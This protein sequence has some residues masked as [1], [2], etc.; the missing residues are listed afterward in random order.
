MNTDSKKAEQTCTIADVTHRFFT[1]S[2][3]KETAD[4]AQKEFAAKEYETKQVLDKIK[5]AAELGEYSLETYH[6]ENIAKNL[7]LIGYNVS[8]GFEGRFHQHYM[9]V[10]WSNGG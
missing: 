2:M 5:E 3:A 9:T 8:D 4:N 7:R 6:D 1:P 10:D